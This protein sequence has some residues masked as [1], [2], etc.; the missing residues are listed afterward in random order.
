MGKRIL[1]TSALPYANGPIHIG[2]LVE[3][4]QTDIWV[5]FLRMIGEDVIYICAD[6]THGTPIEIKAK[7]EG[8]TPEELITYYYKEHLEDFTSF[9][10][11]FDYYGSTHTEENKRWAEYIY[12]ALKEGGYIEEREV[13]LMYC[14]YDKRFLPDRYIRGVCPRCGA[15]EQYGDQCEVCNSTYE[16]LDLKEAKCAICGNKPIV[17]RSIHEFVKLIK[18]EPQLREWLNTPQRVHPTIKNYI[19]VWLNEGLKD[20]DITRDSPYFGFKVPG[21]EDKYFYVWLDAPIGYISNT[22]RW[23]KLKGRDVEKDYWKDPEAQ[24]YHFIGRD[25]VYFHTLFW[26]AMLMASGLT[27]P[28]AIFVHGFLTVE[29]QKMSKSRGTFITAKRYLKFFDPLYLRYYYASKLTGTPEDIDLSFVDFVNK[30]NSELV[31]KIANLASRVVSFLN[32]KLESFISEPEEEGYKLIEETLKKKDEI[33]RYYLELNYAKAMKEICDIAERANL[34][35]Q[36]K[37]PWD[38]LKVDKESARKICTTALNITRM[39]GVYLQPVIPSYSKKIREI[40]NED[41]EKEFFWSDLDIVVKNKKIN[42]FSLLVERVDIERLEEMVEYNKGVE[43]PLTHEE[44]GKEGKGRVVPLPPLEEEISFEDFLK[45]DLRAAK[46]IDV[47]EV[48]GADKLL[49]LTL[50]LGE[51]GRKEV[52]AGIKKSFPEPKKLIGKTIVMVANLKPRKFKFG[53]S[54]GMIL[55]VGEDED[56]LCLLELPSNVRAG[57]RVR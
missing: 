57:E 31:N 4:I 41:I 32:K 39:L 34:Y 55:A 3:Y 16:P 17:K 6:D 44:T 30:I 22:E 45:V 1:V 20:W 33:K 5:R 38:M 7:Q 9:D 19:M 11:R 47:T 13:E 37:A 2:H 14:E 15:Q 49:K 48:E 10:I 42:Q 52:F 27:L 23:C 40:L 46:I 51:L 26:P 24:I 21:Y 18:F 25:I 50:D 35:F 53:V 56:R 36:E 8:V 12:R 28:K 54:H 29:G 43:R